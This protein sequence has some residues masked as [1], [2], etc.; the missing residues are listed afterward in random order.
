MVKHGPVMSTTVLART[1]R[2]VF[3]FDLAWLEETIF[4][5]GQLIPKEPSVPTSLFWEMVAQEVIPANGIDFHDARAVVYPDV[6]KPGFL[7]APTPKFVEV[8]SLT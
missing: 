1:L 6:A 4:T 7:S 8:K 2:S 5:S 3:L